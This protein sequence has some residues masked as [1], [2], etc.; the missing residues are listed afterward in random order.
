M[1][2]GYLTLTPK[3]YFAKFFLKNKKERD[4]LKLITVIIVLYIALWDKLKL[5][6]LLGSVFT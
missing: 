2:S 6:T 5:I 4:K 3:K 1:N